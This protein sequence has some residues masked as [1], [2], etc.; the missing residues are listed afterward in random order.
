MK[1]NAQSKK[2]QTENNE[3][4]L[5]WIKNSKNGNVSNVNRQ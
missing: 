4:K 2:G 1:F 5:N 3:L